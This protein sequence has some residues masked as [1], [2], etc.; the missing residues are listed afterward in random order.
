M[1]EMRNA[2]GYKLTY[3]LIFHLEKGEFTTVGKDEI[4][5]TTKLSKVY[6]SAMDVDYS[7]IANF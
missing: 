5:H 3:M 4:G 7:F 2:R 1:Q 6:Q